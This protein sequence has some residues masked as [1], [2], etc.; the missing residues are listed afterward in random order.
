MLAAY[1][2]ALSLLAV[3]VWLVIDALLSLRQPGAH[4][5]EVDTPHHLLQGHGLG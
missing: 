3:A 2:S 1:T 4:R 5:S